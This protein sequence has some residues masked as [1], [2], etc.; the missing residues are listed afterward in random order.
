MALRRID[1]RH[2]EAL[3][4]VAATR[5]IEKTAA[6][7]LPHHTLMA[8]AGLAVARLAQALAPHARRVWVVCGPG[9]NGGDGLVAARHLHQWAQAAGGHCE[10]VVSMHSGTIT[11][12]DAAQALSDAR[13]AGVRFA[14]EPPEAW[15]LGIDALLGI[16]V[17]RAPEGA[18][19][20]WLG[21]LHR[22]AS[23]CLCIDVPSGLDADTGCWAAPPE[24]PSRAQPAGPRHTL[25]LLT[26]KP[27]LFTA[28][29]RDQTGQVWFDDLRCSASPDLPV[30][31][32]LAGRDDRGAT[33]TLRAHASHKGSRADVAVIGGQAITLHGAGMTGAAI[34]AARAA[35]H[36]G[37]G[38]VL[39]GLLG[40]E[41]AS[42]RWDPQSPELMFRR[43]ALLLQRDALSQSA[44]VCGCGGG[45]AV[46]DVLPEVMAGA[47]RLVLDADALNAIARDASLQTQLRHRGERGA[48]TVLT[49]H[50]LEA[51][52]LL[53]GDT[54][55]VMRDRLQAGRALAARYGAVCVL[56][57]SGTVIAAP[58]VTPQINPTGN[59]ALATAGTGDVL[60]GLV[61]AALADPQDA[62]LAALHDR[63]AAAVFQHGWLADQWVADHP[64]A[65][66][67]DRLASRVR[68]VV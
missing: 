4:G 63:V 22:S 15:D 12:P 18:L 19:A 7:T 44:V 62:S 34:L 52:R 68:R 47:W 36:A 1:E 43:I 65:L 32:W 53:G 17:A 16:G 40:D 56:K 42:V 51:A 21:L 66:S 37:A 64:E 3:Y 39:V 2:R 38:R 46:A 48:F 50:P 23:P 55:E 31:A 35:L 26:V 58:G 60:A 57:G 6:A 5:D 49:P 10:V 8:R 20:Q 11:P 9:N 45:E 59:A 29:G 67:A 61:G 27:G 33:Q 41:I 14:E 30:A 25:S 13:S 24:W 28:H 54:A